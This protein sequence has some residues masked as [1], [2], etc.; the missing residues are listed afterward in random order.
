MEQLKIADTSA[1]VLNWT[2]AS[3][4]QT[5][6]AQHYFQHLNLSEADRLLALF[7]EQERRMHTECV[8]GRKFFMRKCALSFIAKCQEQQHPA[9]IIILAAG[10]APLSVELAA[11]FPQIKIFDV[12][13]DL[14]AEKEKMLR[15]QFSN[16]QFLTCDISNLENLTQQLV[17]N[18]WDRQQPTLVILEGIIYYL[19]EEDL[20][21]I[22]RY[23]SQNHA[24][25]ACDFALEP[26]C[27]DMPN[28]TFG[29]DVFRK[30]EQA[31]G[32]PKVRFYTPG[33]FTKML[34][35]CGYQN[36]QLQTSANIQTERT[37]RAAPFEGP[38]S[39][40]IN[41]IQTS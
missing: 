14:M 5:E 15:N 38:N 9:Q 18:G 35:S 40:W 19:E 11:L 3:V 23:F 16:I 12:D 25:L 29:M 7:N 2:S 37:G 32:I 26:E 36:V 22:L 41:F 24:A 6:P 27:V 39:S 1:L 33:Y 30:I 4:W 20:E 8:S 13:R 21:N 17:D 10:I 34:E 31:T 28:R